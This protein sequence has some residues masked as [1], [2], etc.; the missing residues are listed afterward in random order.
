MYKTLSLCSLSVLFALVGCSSALGQDWPGWRGANRDA[1]VA[2]FKAPATWPESLGTVWKVTIGEGHS[3]PVVAA[4]KVY[5]FARQ[6][7]LEVA[8]C[9][10]LETGKVVWS[11]S[12]PVSY[13]MHPAAVGHGKGPKSTSVVSGGKLYTL[14]ITGVVSCFDAKTGKLVWRKEFA[15]RFKTTSPLFGTAMSPIIDRGLLIAHLGGHDSGALIAF[16]AATGAE[17]WSWNGDGPGYASPVIVEAGGL[18]QVVTQSQKFVIGVAEA[19]G[20][21]L[22]QIPFTTEYVQN[23]VTP[24]V[25]NQMI[26]YSGLDKGTT[27]IKIVREA[28]KWTTQQVWHNPDISMYMN[29]PVVRGDL[30]FGLCHKR[31]GEFF[32]LDARTGKTLWTGD[33][34]QGENAAI[35]EGGDTLFLLTN[36]AEL[37]VAKAT[38]DGFKLLKKYTVAT[39]PTWAHPV[40]VGNRI[41]IKDKMTL[42]LLSLR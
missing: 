10:D 9:I 33:G 5:T 7:D 14:G 12:Y 23:A 25:Y 31:K 4:G 39:S 13:K 6:D 1:V 38:G 36:D 17:R 22:W 15:D 26:I 35:L 21:L 42:A 2:S 34:R 19:T 18:R 30:L 32:C 16:D 3:T 27:A 8:S 29:S 28:G 24:V 37:M 20:E 41:L 40:L 11:E